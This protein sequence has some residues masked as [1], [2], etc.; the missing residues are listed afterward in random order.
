MMYVHG[1]AR[2]GARALARSRRRAHSLTWAYARGL[3]R[4]HAFARLHA[5]EG[6]LLV[7][8]APA[9]FFV[10]MGAHTRLPASARVRRARTRVRQPR[11]HSSVRLCGTAARE[12]A[13]LPV[14]LHLRLRASAPVR[15]C[16]STPVLLCASTPVRQYACALS[17]LYARTFA[18]LCT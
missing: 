2:T 17:R 8:L 5:R 12:D 9:S 11:G 15:L 6:A 10:C 16:A 18:V 13:S 14:P 3:A 7:V 1:Q 4:L